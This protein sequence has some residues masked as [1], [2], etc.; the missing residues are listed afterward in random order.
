MLVA[1]IIEKNQCSLNPTIN[2]LHG[3]FYFIDGFQ[4]ISLAYSLPQL[5][6]VLQKEACLVLIAS[7]YLV[8]FSLSADA[9][10]ASTDLWRYN[11]ASVSTKIYQTIT[12]FAA[13]MYYLLLNVTLHY[14]DTYTHYI[15]VN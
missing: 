6:Q 9:R 1:H 4:E 12:W 3:F 10:T 11:W 2:I 7:E 13:D 5:P 14:F 8:V 15:F